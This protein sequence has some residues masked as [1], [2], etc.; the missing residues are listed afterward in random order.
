MADFK[1]FEF[2][3]LPKSSVVNK[4]NAD[5]ENGIEEFINKTVKEHLKRIVPKPEPYLFYTKD[6]E[7]ELPEAEVDARDGDNKVADIKE[8]GSENFG[9]ESI[10]EN[11]N[12]DKTSQKGENTEILQNNDNVGGDLNKDE[13]GKE[14]GTF[15]NLPENIEEIK[16][17][18]F[19][20]GFKEAEDK[21]RKLQEN[22]EKDSNVIEKLLDKLSQLKP[23]EEF[24][25]KVAKLSASSI[26]LIAKKLHMV[27]PVNFEEILYQGIIEKLSKFYQEGIISVTVHPDRHDSCSKILQSDYIPAK[28][29]GNFKI[30]VDDKLS[31]NDCRVDW[32]DTHL[33][34]SMEQLSE[35]IDRIIERLTNAA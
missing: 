13:Q 33:E 10:Q 7:T 16:R 29:K 22:E 27:L 14:G 9:S 1:K 17:I 11:A 18:E 3:D 24:D 35:E 25:L 15:G 8:F 32:K 34:Y 12:L 19:E 30:V 4:N 21:Y 5:I 6:F 2:N 31:D 23:E 28:F 20:R 26:S